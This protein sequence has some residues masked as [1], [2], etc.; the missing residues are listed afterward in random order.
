MS[1]TTALLVGEAWQSLQFDIKGF[2]FFSRSTYHE[3]ITPLQ[4][5][6]EANGITTEYIPTTRAARE[7]PTSADEVADYDAIVLSDVGYNTLALP[8]ATFDSF[9]R[10]P[11]RLQL[12]EDFVKAG[13]GLI[14]VGGYLSFQGFNG[15]ANYKNTPVET[16]LPVTMQSHDDRVE[17]SDGVIPVVSEGSHT[18][19]D[20]LPE[21]WPALLGYNRVVPDSD[22]EELVRVDD[23]PLVVVGDYGEGRSAAFT[24]DCAPHWA[25]PRFTDWDR[26]DEVWTNLV[27]W[28]AGE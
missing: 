7:F 3:S 27:E 4:E 18:I 9:E 12:T 26:Y 14:M 11:N 21:E 8:P 2:D 5:A 19:V 6:L 10:I 13:G 17:R 1:E 15:K 20:G 25:A 24:S 22:A 28:V 16:A 23:D